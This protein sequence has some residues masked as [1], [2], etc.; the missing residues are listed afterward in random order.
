MKKIIFA[1]LLGSPFAQAQTHHGLQSAVALDLTLPF[2]FE[3][4]SENKLDVRA[5]ELTFMGALQPH[6]DATL[7][8]AAH[9]EEGEF[10]VE[11]HEAF[12][13]ADKVVPYSNLR[14]GKFLLS[15]GQLNQMHRHEWN[16]VSAPRV[17][18]AFFDEENVTDTG[19]EIISQFPAASNWEFTAGVTNGYTFGHSHDQGEKPQVPTHYLRPA[20]TL[21]LG[22]SG[23]LK[24]GLNYVGRTDA[25]SLQTQLYGLDVLFRKIEGDTTSVLLQSE[26]WYRKQ[27]APQTNDTEEVGAY[28]YPQMSLSERLFVGVRFDFFQELDRTNP[29]DGSSQE[30]LNYAFVPTLTFQS[31]EFS[32]MRLAYTY[33]QQT[34]EGESDQLNQKIEL[35]W[36]AILGDQHSH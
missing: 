31:S 7:N 11:V 4:S 36:V 24:W 20:H 16:F 22:G 5:V 14:V 34:Y 27:S 19:A 15:V 9:D 12:I 26:I 2:N 8:L 3:E 13:S 28:F 23:N 35:Q 30:N 25:E 21:D 1:L 18:S 10:V 29:I 33:D 17:Q 32:K 6:I